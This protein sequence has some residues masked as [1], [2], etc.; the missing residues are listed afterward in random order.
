MNQFYAY[1]P[2]A[3]ELIRGDVV[4]W[5]QK[6]RKKSKNALVPKVFNQAKLPF[7]GE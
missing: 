3:D 7:R 1:V 6:Y 4:K 5:L 2:A